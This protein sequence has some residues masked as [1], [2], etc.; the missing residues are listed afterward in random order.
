MKKKARGCKAQPT[1]STKTDA[2]PAKA[3]VLP[4]VSKKQGPVKVEWIKGTSMF[5]VEGVL[6]PQEAQQFVQAMEGSGLLTHQS[7]RGPK[8]GEAYR[9]NDRYSVQDEAFAS[10]LW[11]ASGLRALFEG[12]Q[13]DG[14]CAVGLNPNIRLYRYK[15]GQRFGKHVDG[16]QELG[17][18]R[19]TQ[20]TL[21]LYLNGG[22]PGAGGATRL[23]GGE[24][25]FYT[26]PR[27]RLLASVAPRAGMALLHIHGDYCLEHEALEVTAGAKYVLRSDVVFARR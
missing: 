15:A 9:D 7:S 16:S 20:Y 21:L 26:G 13:V 10:A 3:L 24:T 5:Q 25:A 17:G 6:S 19:F 4:R 12:I 23:V 11:E 8:Y 1:G 18:G 27:S 2:V 14:C 22:P